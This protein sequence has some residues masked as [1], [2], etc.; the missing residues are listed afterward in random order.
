[1]MKYL[2]IIP[3]LVYVAASLW[4][5]FDL[6]PKDLMQYWWLDDVGHIIVFGSLTLVALTFAHSKHI[7]PAAAVSS[8]V[9]LAIVDELSQLFLIYRS[10]TYHDL[11]MSLVGIALVSIGYR[12]FILIHK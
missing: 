6:F 7:P 9:A 11:A 12:L 3:V 2:L 8:I 1:M 5:N 4:A 10:F